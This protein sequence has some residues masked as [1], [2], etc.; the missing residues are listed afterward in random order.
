SPYSTDSACWAVAT[1]NTS[2]SASAAASLMV[3][4]ALTPSPARAA[5]LCGSMSKA[6]TVCP[7]RATQLAMGAPM[8]PKPIHPTVVIS[9]VFLL[10]VGWIEGGW[11]SASGE[12]LDDVGQGVVVTDV[13]GEHD[14]GGANRFGG[15]FD[16]PEHRDHAGQELADDLGAP[17]SEP[18]DGDVVGGDAA[19]RDHPGGMRCQGGLD[20][21]DDGG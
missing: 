19:L 2:T 3:A 8:A 15:G 5:A 16:G 12:H 6:V 13:A 20:H 14:G 18:S 1:I 17:N 21:L 10:L 4:A 7:A 11:L 9:A